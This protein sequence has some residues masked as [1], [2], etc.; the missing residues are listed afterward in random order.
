MLSAG[1]GGGVA[2][3]G[4]AP[5]EVRDAAEFTAALRE[6][7]VRTRLSYR[8]L[9][10]RAE[11]VGDVLPASTLS[12]ALSRNTLPRPQLL[13]ACIRACGGDDQ[14]VQ[15]WTALRTALAV[16]TVNP[17]NGAASTERA[18]D[19]AT[20]TA[21][22]EAEPSS[23]ADPAASVAAAADSASGTA[24]PAPDAVADPEPAAEPP[25]P[26]DVPATAEPAATTAFTRRRLTVV[27][28]VLAVVAVVV[29]AV[30]LA[31]GN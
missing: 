17:V 10:R 26:V 22:E 16:A 18:A 30:V 12:T 27:A 28:G 14:A 29:F 2:V 19:P 20:A 3:E 11:R 25:A 21:A 1:L 23:V 4:L 15:A 5:P 31:D 9:E 13:S 24:D 8:Q 7:R 6:L